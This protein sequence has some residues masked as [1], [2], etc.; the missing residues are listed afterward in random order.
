VSLSCC[1]VPPAQCGGGGAPEYVDHDDWLEPK[2][3]EGRTRHSVS[4][5]SGSSSDSVFVV[6]FVVQVQAARHATSLWAHRTLTNSVDRC[7][8][9]WNSLLI[10]Q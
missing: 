9:S 2:Y 6:V 5:R 4:Q 1:G 7:L 3:G 10:T 8:E